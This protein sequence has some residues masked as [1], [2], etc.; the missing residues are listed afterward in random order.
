MKPARAATRRYLPGSPF[1][2]QPA[3]RPVKQFALND[4]VTHDKYG[5]GRVISV[6][7]EVAV[8]VDFGTTRQRISA[9]YAKL[10]RL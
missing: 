4:Q 10:I 2:N 5:L 8:V 7:D 6:E 3:P 1:N 9:P